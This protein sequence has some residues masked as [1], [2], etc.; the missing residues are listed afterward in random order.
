M[1][2]HLGLETHENIN[3][4]CRLRKSIYGL[5]QSPRA[6]FDRFTKA[7]KKCGYSQCQTDHTLFVKHS[8]SKITVL[9]VYV[10]DIILTGND[11]DEV[12]KLKGFLARE[13][14]IKDLGGLKYFLGMEIV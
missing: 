4:V 12:Q 10:D 1:D 11:D 3:K 7:V 9:I 8:S 13:F 2:I 5:K 6:W 14:E